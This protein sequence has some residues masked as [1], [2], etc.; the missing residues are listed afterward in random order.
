MIA[1]F[2]MYFVFNCGFYYVAGFLS[3]RDAIK[4]AMKSSYLKDQSNPIIFLM[5]GC[6]FPYILLS[7]FIDLVFMPINLFIEKI[8]LPPW[9]DFTFMDK[10]KVWTI[11]DPWVYIQIYIVIALFALLFAFARGLI[12]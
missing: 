1:P 6:S 12:G 8:I 7:F 3:S 10:D 11:G 9:K 5:T 4:E 2:Q